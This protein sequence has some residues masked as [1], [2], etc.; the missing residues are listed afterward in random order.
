MSR[1]SQHMSL[2]IKALNTLRHGRSAETFPLNTPDVVLHRAGAH[3]MTHATPTEP[4]QQ[5]W[6]VQ[7]YDYMLKVIE[8]ERQDQSLP[9]SGLKVSDTLILIMPI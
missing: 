7:T 1:S 5:D 9:R 4:L 3:W 6:D 2:V 8:E